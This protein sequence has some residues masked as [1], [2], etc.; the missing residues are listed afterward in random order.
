MTNSKKIREI[1]LDT[2][3]TGLNYQDGDR[4]VDIGCVEL[5]DHLPSGN[6]FQVYINPEKKMSADAARISG[7]TDEFLADKPVFSKIVDDFLNFVGDST[8]VIH[9]AKFDVDFLNSE[10]ERLQK[11]L[12]SMENVIDTLDIAH[13]KFPGAPASL[14]A[15]CKR[16][17]IDTSI[18]V[19]HGALVDSLLLAD[20]YINLIEERQKNLFAETVSTDKNTEVF[21][22]QNKILN[23]PKRSFPPSDEEL[24]LHQKFIE[25]LTNPMWNLDDPQ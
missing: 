2:E 10:L 9:N 12:F 11:P 8:L 15:L 25:T 7:I 14:D 22:H 4:V 13:R 20:V 21:T 23:L 3:T 16:F 5:I 18:R 19:T 1:V 6:T 24:K 17:N